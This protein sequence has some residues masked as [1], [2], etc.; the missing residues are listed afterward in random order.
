MIK[1]HTLP[2]L[3]DTVC[4]RRRNQ[5]WS[6]RL[7]WYVGSCL[8]FHS[9]KMWL[10]FVTAGIWSRI[11]F[12][13]LKN[14]KTLIWLETQDRRVL[15]NLFG[16]REVLAYVTSTARTGGTKRLFFS[17]ISPEELQIFCAWQESS[18][19]NQTGSDRMK[20]IPLFLYSFRWYWNQ[21]LWTENFLVAMQLHGTE[22]QGH[23]DDD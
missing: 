15:T 7:P 11:W 6:S 17:T 9:R 16:T 22:L 5:N 3:S 23:W 2:F 19:L 14:M 1:S 10:S 13:S 21:L 8:N 12:L 18:P 20:Y 4:G